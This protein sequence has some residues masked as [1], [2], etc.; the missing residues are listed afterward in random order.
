MRTAALLLAVAL[1][2]ACHSAKPAKVV[3]APPNPAGLSDVDG[4][5]TM[6]MF[7]SNQIT[8]RARTKVYL[9]IADALKGVPT[10]PNPLSQSDAETA[11]FKGY[12]LRMTVSD[13]QLHFQTS[14][15][16]ESRESACGKSWFSTEQ[17][18]IYVGQVIGCATN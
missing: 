3:A 15:T 11:T 17:G 10:V 9:P 16:P 14:L 13:D 7:L 5:L 12:R 2:S 18:L 4:L 8:S 6:R 1:A